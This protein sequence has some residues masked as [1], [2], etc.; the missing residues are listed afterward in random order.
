MPRDYTLEA[1]LLEYLSTM[2]FGDVLD[3]LDE[4]CGE[5]LVAAGARQE[6]EQVVLWSLRRGALRGMREP[7]AAER[8]DDAVRLIET[9]ARK[10]VAQAG[11]PWPPWNAQAP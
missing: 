10:I 1:A 7:L 3:L 5:H 6:T 9:W 2:A 11:M 4:L 8:F